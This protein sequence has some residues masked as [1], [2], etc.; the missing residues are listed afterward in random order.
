[1]DQSPPGPSHKDVE[2]VLWGWQQGSPRNLTRTH[3]KLIKYRE[4][5]KVPV[6]W[7]G[8]KAESLPRHRYKL[9]S[10]EVKGL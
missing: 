5:S 3:F 6:R 1:M 9:Q 7:D 2:G 8:Q 4:E 10:R